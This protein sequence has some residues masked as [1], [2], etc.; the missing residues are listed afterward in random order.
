VSG[1]AWSSAPHLGRERLPA[2][3]TEA[4]P[5]CDA[6]I[7]YSMVPMWKRERTDEVVSAVMQAAKAN[8]RPK[9]KRVRTKEQTRRDYLVRKQREAK[10]LEEQK[11]G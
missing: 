8:P 10:Q 5:D 7:G 1:A 3:F 4:L 2:A 11:A 9:K 6:H